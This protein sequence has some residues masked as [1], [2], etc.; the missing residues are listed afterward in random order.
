[1]VIFHFSELTQE[2]LKLLKKGD[3]G[4]MREILEAENFEN[5]GSYFKRCK[6]FRTITL[7][8]DFSQNFNFDVR[9]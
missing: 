7:S 8:N 1:M 6:I 9:K 5:V 4:D 2:V 3:Q